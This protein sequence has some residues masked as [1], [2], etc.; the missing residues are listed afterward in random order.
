VRKEGDHA[1]DHRNHH[2][3]LGADGGGDSGDV[4]YDAPGDYAHGRSLTT[5]AE[6]KKEREV[7]P[8]LPLSLFS[9]NF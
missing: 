4:R 8:V 7:Q 9:G 2:E 3:H 6:K 5:P 1:D